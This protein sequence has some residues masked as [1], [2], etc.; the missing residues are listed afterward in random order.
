[1]ETAPRYPLAWPSGWKRT[2]A[3]QRHRAAFRTGKQPLTVSAA[4]G[5]LARELRLLNAVD[6]VL[7]TNVAVRIDGWPRSGQA[8]PSDPGAAAYFKIAG[9]PTV[10]A[11]DRW[12]RVADNIAA[13]AQHID[14]LRRIDRYGVGTL[15][16]AFAGY[17][18]LPERAGG[19]EA[20]WEVLGVAPQ[21]SREGVEIA[22]RELAR[23][24]HPDAGGD[25]DRMARLNRARDEARRALE[26]IG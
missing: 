26:A 9:T 22:Y 15:E 16:Q 23:T 18:A 21:A 5:R 2:P 6:E 17:A 14:A 13:V 11:C 25:H 19:V 20:W 8:E 4:L 7:S 1:M 12:T 24:L 3:S 10:L